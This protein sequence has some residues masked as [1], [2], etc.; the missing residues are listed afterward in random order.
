[1]AIVLLISCKESKISESSQ[2]RE[3]M[4]LDTLL[5]FADEASLAQAFGK[6]NVTRDTLWYPEASG[7][8]VVS[9]L[10]ANSPRKVSVIWNDSI[11]FSGL[12]EVFIDEPGTRWQTSEGITVGTPLSSLVTLNKGPLEFMGLEWDYGGLVDWSNGALQHR[13]LQVTLGL[14]EIYDTTANLDSLIGDQRISSEWAIAKK[15]NPVAI[16]VSLLKEHE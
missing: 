8:Y 7:Q 2:A 16:K 13:R 3:V 6:N 10:Y 14:P 11:N 9:V 5:S 12:S 1:M 15:I 4:I